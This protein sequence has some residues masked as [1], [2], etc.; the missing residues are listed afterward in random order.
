M[1]A[2][3][4]NAD[5]TG[6]V[7]DFEE[8]DSYKMIQDAVGGIFQ[9][10][11]LNKL[12]VTMWMHDEGKILNFPV[13]P[14][15]TLFWSTEYGETDVIV[16]NIILTGPTGPDGETTGLEDDFV[17]LLLMSQHGPEDC[18]QGDHEH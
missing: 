18:P 14:I 10:I 4:F 12:G 5:S 15:G 16:G 3:I 6:G 17:T 13:N 1:K 7:I 8:V 9:A 11:S 2:A